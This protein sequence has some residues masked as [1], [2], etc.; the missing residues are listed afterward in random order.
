MTTAAGEVDAAVVGGGFAGLALAA[1]LAAHGRRVTVIERRVERAA[2]RRVVILQPPGLAALA[3]VGALAEAIERGTRL[4][5]AV[6][7]RSDGRTRVTYDYSELDHPHPFFLVVRSSD[8]EEVLARRVAELDPGA[9]SMGCSFEDVLRDGAVAGLRYRDR[10]GRERELRAGCVVGADGAGSRVR[11]ALGIDVIGGEWADSY[12]LGVGRE[13]AAGRAREAT[14]YCGRGYANL[15][16]PH[17]ESSYF[18]DHV[19]SDVHRAIE[20]RDLDAWR[21]LY[22]E[23]LPDGGRLAATVESWDDVTVR[24]ARPF[25]ASRMVAPGAALIGDAAGVVSPNSGQGGSLALT[26][27]L[28]LADALA[29]R[30]EAWSPVTEAELAVYAG[31]RARKLRAQLAWTRLV[32]Q[33]LNAPTVGWRAVRALGLACNRMAPVRSALLRRTAGLG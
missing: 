19:T 23:R 18:W 16:V 8:L 22:A 17:G 29:G 32:A 28:A 7:R 33:S 2:M 26:D 25:R 12:L 15:V 13:S 24:T 6:L 10:E 1:R 30:G 9:V 5:R 21:R 3:E 14:F 31:P 20:A 4:E 11:A 27:A